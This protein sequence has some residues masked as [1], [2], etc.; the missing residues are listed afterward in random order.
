MSTLVT[1]KKENVVDEVYNQMMQQIVSA[2]WPQNS[3]IPSENELRE[4][5][6]V[7]RDT[8]RQA[9]KRLC[10][11]GLLVSEQ[12]RGT[13]VQKIDVGF[14]MNLLAPT[15]FL[16]D[17]DGSNILSF[18]KAIQVE[19]ARKVAAS[20]D[21]EAVSILK[22]CM[23]QMR[24]TDDPVEFFAYDNEFHTRLAELSGNALFIKSMEIASK[25]LQHYLT[26]LVVIHG[27]RQSIE[28]HA[29]CLEAIIEHDPDR[30]AQEMCA[31]YDMLAVRLQSSM[32]KQKAEQPQ[33]E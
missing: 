17:D 25:L 18:M 9:I 28:Q 13:F 21:A 8:V 6:G 10:A 23:E 31:H 24:K 1:L 32:A 20:A 26:E 2:E 16:S 29:M 11:L 19:S 5:L 12:G 3:K 30:A 7:S 27:N 33:T 22:Q 15:V 14:Y 4:A